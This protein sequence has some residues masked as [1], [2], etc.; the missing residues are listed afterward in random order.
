MRRCRASITL[1]LVATVDTRNLPHILA[2]EPRNVAD[3]VLAIV[4]AA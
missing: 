4:E 1:K 3:R 2:D